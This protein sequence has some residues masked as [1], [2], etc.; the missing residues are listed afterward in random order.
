MAISRD[1]E[2]RLL[3]AVAVAEPTTLQAI[4]KVELA[5][6]AA[7]VVVKN[8]GTLGEAAEHPLRAKETLVAVPQTQ[9]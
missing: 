1:W 2:R 7:A 5:A 4:I 9:D 8:Q 6:Q 3:L